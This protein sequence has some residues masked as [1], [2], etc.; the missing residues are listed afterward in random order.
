MN[1]AALADY[2]R[3][4]HAAAL[5]R[6]APPGGLS[7]VCRRCDVTGFLRGGSYLGA[8]EDCADGGDG[9]DGGGAE[10]VGD[11]DA[12]GCEGVEDGGCEADP[13]GG[14]AR[15]RQAAHRLA[16]VHS[17]ALRSRIVPPV[18]SEPEEEMVLDVFEYQVICE[19]PISFG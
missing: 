9:G 10:V 17:P 8:D 4:A 7:Y 1:V 3:R 12:G 19:W 5:P 11:G 15:E 2:R 16:S 6:I 18:T 13:R 14:F